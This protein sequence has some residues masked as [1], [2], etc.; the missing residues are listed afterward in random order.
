MSMS[1]PR[2][3]PVRDLRVCVL[4]LTRIPVG[5]IVGLATDDLGRAAWAF[6]LAGLMVGAI[7]GG[8]LYIVAAAEVSPLGCALVALAVQALVTGALHEDGLA[9]VADGMGAH[10]RDRRLEIM[11]DS[12]IGTYGV[13]ALLFSVG[14]RAAMIAGIPAPGYA[15]MAI[16]AAAIFSRAV[17]PAVMHAMVPARTDGLSQNAGQPSARG[18]AIAALIGALGLFTLLPLSVALGAVALALVLGGAVTWWA[19]AKFGGQTGDVLGAIQQMIE[20]AVV[21]AAAAWSSTFYA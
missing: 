15:F 18:A 7:A 8:A 16:I 19:H 4:F 2:F 9:D 20:I 12:R 6:P 13:L 17:L 1:E 14:I 21:T 5:R 11:R 3:S 10:E